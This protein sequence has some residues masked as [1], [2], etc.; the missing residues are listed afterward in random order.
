MDASEL[1]A[2]ARIHRATGGNVRETKDTKMW[3][4]KDEESVENLVRYMLTEGMVV[5]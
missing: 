3:E 1:T 2:V 4:C 5:F